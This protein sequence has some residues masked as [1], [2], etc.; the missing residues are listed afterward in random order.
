[1]LWLSDYSYRLRTFVSPQTVPECVLLENELVLLK[2]N[3]SIYRENA[4]LLKIFSSYDFKKAVYPPEEYKVLKESIDKII[5]T[6][7]RELVMVPKS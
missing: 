7:D 2:V 1:M 5:A 6:L 4:D 3:T